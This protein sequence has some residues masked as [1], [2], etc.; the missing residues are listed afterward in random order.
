MIKGTFV[1][2]RAIEEVD[3][4]QLLLWRN[5]PSLRRFFRE[6]RELNFTQQLEWF[7]KKVNHD[8]STRMFSI[9]DIETNELLG[10]C[11]LCYIDWA[12]RTA[13]FSI[14]LGHKGL[15]IDSEYAPEAAHL[16]IGYG[17]DELSLN[18]LWSE[19]YSFDKQKSVFF[20]NLGF[21]LEGTHRQTHWGEGFWCDSLFYALLRSDLNPIK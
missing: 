2:L 3:L 15:Y 5:D 18:R 10:A 17:F 1:G 21:K 12:N 4:H 13:D 20:N 8:A 16:L 7:D 9:V 11:G 6:Y 14:Y 19:I